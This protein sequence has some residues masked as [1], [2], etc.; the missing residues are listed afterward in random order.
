MLLEER[1]LTGHCTGAHIRS[2][3]AAALT[4]AFT[5][6]AVA[7]VKLALLHWHR[8]S[9]LLVPVHRY[10]PIFRYRYRYD[11]YRIVLIVVDYRYYYS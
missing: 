6:P 8:S 1:A 4:A 9:W 11:I 3:T 2:P 7:S 5:L 10:L